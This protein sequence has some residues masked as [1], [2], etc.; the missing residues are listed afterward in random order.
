VL[1]VDSLLAAV[2]F[3]VAVAEFAAAGG[4]NQIHAD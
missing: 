1:K 4:E 2:E 3:A